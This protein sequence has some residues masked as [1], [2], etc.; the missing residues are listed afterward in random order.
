VPTA[1]LEELDGEFGLYDP[2]GQT[3]QVVLDTDYDEQIENPEPGL[4]GEEML[5]SSFIVWSAGPD[6][7]FDTWEDNICSWK[8]KK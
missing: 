1:G 2:W 5:K 3:Y 4:K 6:G 7:D 8:L